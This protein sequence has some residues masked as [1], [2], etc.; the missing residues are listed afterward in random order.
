MS[1]LETKAHA[2]TF[3]ESINMETNQ[4]CPK[5]YQQFHCILLRKLSPLTVF[6]ACLA[7]THVSGNFTRDLHGKPWVK[8]DK[9]TVSQPPEQRGTGVSAAEV[10]PPCPWSLL[11]SL[12]DY[13]VLVLPGVP[14]Y[15][16]H[17][18]FTPT[19]ACSQAF[20]HSVTISPG[21]L[22][23]RLGWVFE[24][25][26]WL[27]TKSWKCF[28][29]AEYRENKMITNIYG[30]MTPPRETNSFSKWS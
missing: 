1:V 21:F 25:Q 19:H 7:F 8:R 22:E 18:A 30:S 26:K 29:C 23:T 24:K 12:S 5:W 4:Q 15:V 9:G 11:S 6:P 10:Q 17:K 28:N 27:L 2:P 3:W 20:P 14:S 16:P 13:R